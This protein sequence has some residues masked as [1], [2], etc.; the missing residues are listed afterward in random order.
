M[1]GVVCCHRPLPA[2]RAREAVRTLGQDA[3]VPGGGSSGR[4]AF[5]APPAG[6]GEAGLPRLLPPPSRRSRHACRTSPAAS[7]GCQT[8]AAIAGRR[9][10]PLRLRLSVHQSPSPSSPTRLP[11][12]SPAGR[13][14]HRR[15]GRPASRLE[16]PPATGRRRAS[17]RWSRPSSH[18]SYRLCPHSR[19]AAQSCCR[20]SCQIR[21]AAPGEL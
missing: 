20:H 14:G 17:S 2:L 4:P 3:A 6:P 19:R 10:Q 21:A 5:D 11:C 8:A 9:P 1:N 18:P 15:L 16:L 13:R 7:W 12:C